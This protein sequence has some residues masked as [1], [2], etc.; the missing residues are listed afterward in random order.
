MHSILLI[1]PDFLIILMGAFI[2]WK[3]GY[4]KQFWQWTEKLVFY[5]LFPP[6]LF[7]SIATSKLSFGESSQFLIVALITMSIGVLMA[8]GVRYVVRSDNI[9]HASIF[10]CGFRFNTYIGF[11]LCSRIFGEEGFALLA[12]IMAFWVPISNTLAVGVLAHAVAQAHPERARGNGALAILASTL[13]AVFKNPLI[14]ATLL[15]LAVNVSEIQIPKVGLDFMQHLRKASLAMG[16]LCIGAGLEA[17]G[18]LRNIRL[19][20]AGATV[21]LVLIPCVAVALSWLTGLPGVAAGVLII[22]AALPTGQS[23]YVMTANMGGNAPIVANIT[24]LQTLAAML[25]LPMWMEVMN[26]LLPLI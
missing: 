13:K 1:T 16:L 7:T 21:R 8:W 20:L 19:L 18:L 15:G 6:L 4:P 25:T 3:L 14:V 17:N 11:A 26:Y 5:I 23:C 24:T 10:Q 22:F 12:L 2:T 9:S